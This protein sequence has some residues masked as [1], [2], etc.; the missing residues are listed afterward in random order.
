L[1]SKRAKLKQTDCP[2]QVLYMHVLTFEGHLGISESNLDR[3]VECANLQLD[4]CHNRRPARWFGQNKLPR[5]LW[6]LLKT[7][8]RHCKHN[9][10]ALR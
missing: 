1:V 6:K 9:H 2:V 10:L 8:K 5:R 3:F 7:G 4:L